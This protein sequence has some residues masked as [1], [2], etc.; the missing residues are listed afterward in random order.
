M[1]PYFAYGSNMNIEQLRERLGREGHQLLGRRRATLC[2]YRLVFNKRSSLEARGRASGE[3]EGLLARRPPLL[4]KWYIMEL[5]PFATGSLHL[6]HARNY[7]LADAGARFRRMA[8]Y[9]VLYTTGY[10]TFGLPTEL[11]AREAG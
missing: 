5:P 2:D 8:G 4:P 6:G 11:A 7:V 3:R 10:D 9:D 1:I